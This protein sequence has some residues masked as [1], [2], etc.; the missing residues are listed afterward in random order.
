MVDYTPHYENTVFTMQGD[1]DEYREHEH[2]AVEPTLKQAWPDQWVD[3]GD[4][5]V[6]VDPVGNK[7]W[8][9][10]SHNRHFKTEERARHLDRRDVQ[11]LVG[12][13]KR[14]NAPQLHFFTPT[15]CEIDNMCKYSDPQGRGCKW[16]RG[17][18]RDPSRYGKLPSVSAML[19][20]NTLPNKG[21]DIIEAEIRESERRHAAR[22]YDR[23]GWCR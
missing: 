22:L 18:K 23:S 13:E 12:W 3:W 17:A 15:T 11:A 20:D 21:T 19:Y 5:T 14:H 8:I 4:H 1:A 7:Q 2:A 16:W 6:T 9:D 10:D